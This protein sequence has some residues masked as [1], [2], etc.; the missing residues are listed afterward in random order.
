MAFVDVAINE[1]LFSSVSEF[2]LQNS[3]KAS[4]LSNLLINDAG[5]N[6]T[7]PGLGPES[8]FATLGAKAIGATYFQGR[9]IFV[10]EERDV[11]ALSSDGTT[12]NITGAK[13]G[14][15]RRPF[16]ATDGR[17]LA[18]AGG[19]KPIQYLGGGTTELMPGNAPTCSHMLYLDGYWIANM[20][21][22]GEFAFAGPTRDLRETWNALDFATAEA[23]P[24]SINAIATSIRELHIFGPESVE[25]FQNYGE[26]DVPFVR[27]FTLDNGLVAPYSVINANNTLFWLDSNRRFVESRQRTPVFISNEI[28]SEIQ[29]MT[30]VSDCY[31]YKIDYK[32]QF[33]LVWVF[34]TER[35]SYWYNYKT[36][37]C[38]RFESFVSDTDVTFRLNA[39]AYDKDTNTH[40]VADNTSAKIFKFSDAYLHD[41]DQPIRRIRRTGVI[42]HGTFV[43]K[44]SNRYRIWVKRGMGALDTTEPYLLI[45]FRDDGKPWS[46]FRRVGLGKIGQMESYVEISYREIYRA[47]QIEIVCTDAV[48][49]WINRIQEDVEVLGS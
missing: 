28:H 13:L 33:L 43:R 35:K 34:P 1:G 39:Y 27:I 14:G 16:F 38:G 12:E 18:I 20:L 36:Q 29:A 11:W 17:I 7:R 5:S 42:T 25:I 45:R 44:Q 3:P 47:R 15:D 41:G 21:G 2:E 24:D 4:I 22:T 49:L 8:G 30:V 31:G 10:T 32:D 26:E 48:G 19:G 37:Q 46:A 9:A 23:L 6:Q 40:Y